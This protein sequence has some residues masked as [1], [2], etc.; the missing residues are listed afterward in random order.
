MKKY[1]ILMSNDDEAW[2]RLGPERQQEVIQEHSEFQSALEQDRRLV[3]SH[4]LRPSDETRAVTRTANGS[5]EETAGGYFE[6]N[7]SFGGFYLIEA[8]SMEDAL[9]WARRGRF[10]EGTN[11][12]HEVWD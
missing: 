8:E 4:R 10:I 1:L 11:V 3:L 9:T 12:V 6:Q 5:F 7:R 2:G